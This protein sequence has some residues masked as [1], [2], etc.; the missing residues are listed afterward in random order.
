MESRFAKTSVFPGRVR[1]VSYRRVLVLVLYSRLGGPMGRWGDADVRS[2]VRD[3]K[4]WYPR[5]GGVMRVKIGN[6]RN[7][8]LI[9][10]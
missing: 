10:N 1:L 5:A 8:Q 9:S 2:L 3:S 4:K 7:N 6:N